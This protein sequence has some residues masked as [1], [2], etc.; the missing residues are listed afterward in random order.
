MSLIN[1]RNNK[2]IAPVSILASNATT[3]ADAIN[4]ESG[5]PP[6]IEDRKKLIEWHTAEE[7]AQAILWQHK[8]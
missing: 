3:G 2:G 5:L 8:D 4:I 1:N 6:E 7:V